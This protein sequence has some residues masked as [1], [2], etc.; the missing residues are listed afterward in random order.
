MTSAITV[1]GDDG[2]VFTDTGRGALSWSRRGG[3][4]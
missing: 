1:L 2:D 4:R 3:G